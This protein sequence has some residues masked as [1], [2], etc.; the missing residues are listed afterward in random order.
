MTV[1][2]GDIMDSSAALLSDPAK[3]TFTYALQLPFLSIAWDELQEDL[4][5][6]GI[7]DVD[8]ATTLPIAVTAGTVHL[9]G[10]PDDLL[11]PID[12]WERAVGGVAADWV[13]MTEKKPDPAYQAGETLDIWYWEENFIKFG[14]ATSNREIKILYQKSLLEIANENSTIPV[15]NCKSFLSHR[16]AALIAE[17]RGNK[18]RAQVLHARGDYFLAKSATTKVKDMQEAP[19]RPRRYGYSRRAGR[20]N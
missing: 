11:F 5:S 19:V 18:A 10:Q 17:T 8:E 13:K 6:N 16:T 3:I 14:G 12:V 1:I 15:T 20:R 4:V 7:T 9:S 2:A